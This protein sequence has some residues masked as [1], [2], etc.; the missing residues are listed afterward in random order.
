MYLHLGEDVV[1]PMSRIVGIFD[2]E[3]T[4]VSAHTRA[5]LADAEKGGR[6]VNV[7]QELPRSF[8]VCA[9]PVEG[10]TVYI[11]QISPATL[12]RRMQKAG[13]SEFG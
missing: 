1:V 9:H 5:F 12:L 11:C 10:E 8:V 13:R 6:V 4:T 7:T 2:M 3:N